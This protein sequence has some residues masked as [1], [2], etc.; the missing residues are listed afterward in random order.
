MSF[1]ESLCTMSRYGLFSNFITTSNRQCYAYGALPCALAL[2]AEQ[3][4]HDGNRVSPECGLATL[5]NALVE[6]RAL[7]TGA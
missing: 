5:T 3:F 1:T 2:A 4:A 6:G 7:V